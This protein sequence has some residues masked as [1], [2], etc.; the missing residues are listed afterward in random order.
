MLDVAA[1]QRTW[2]GRELDTRPQTWRGRFPRSRIRRSPDAAP[3][4][5]A[6]AVRRRASW[7]DPS[8]L[9]SGPRTAA[10]W[11]MAASRHAARRTRPLRCAHS[12]NTS[13]S[14][15]HRRITESSPGRC[16]APQLVA[17]LVAVIMPYCIR[18]LVKARCMISRH[19]ASRMTFHHSFGRRMTGHGSHTPTQT[20]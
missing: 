19:H 6:A 1:H 14:W 11:R 8:G 10:P 9:E 17:G 15:D 18:P 13:R 3:R 2:R 16:A 12:G 4:P 7:R 20:E 5:P